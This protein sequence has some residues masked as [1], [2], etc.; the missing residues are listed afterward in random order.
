MIKINIPSVRVV[1]ILLVMVT[2]CTPTSDT[3][4]PPNLPTITPTDT[5]LVPTD[6]LT[7]VPTEPP[8]DEPIPTDA[9]LPSELATE[10]SVFYALPD[11]VFAYLLTPRRDSPGIT[12]EELVANPGALENQVLGR[13]RVVESPTGEFQPGDYTITLEPNLEVLSFNGP[14]DIVRVPVVIRSLPV[15]LPELRPVA[16][17][18]SLQMCLAWDTLQICGLVSTPLPSNLQEQLLGAIQE[19][20]ADP[21]QFDL[22]RGIPDVEGDNILEPCLNDIGQEEPSYRQCRSSVLAVPALEPLKALPADPD[23]IGTSVLVVLENLILENDVFADP[24]FTRPI[25][26]LPPGNYVM[27]NIVFPEDP[28]VPGFENWRA[29]LSRVG[30]SPGVGQDPQYYL[31]AIIGAPLTGDAVVGEPLEEPEAVIS[32]LW[33]RGWDGRWSCYFQWRQCPW[34]S[35]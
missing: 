26:E 1:I 33:V 3:P 20:G 10:Y 23:A 7:E 31:R 15:S 25:G 6:T 11:Q 16:M 30:L 21:E 32:N 34:V 27:Y 18:S 9:A 4:S 28:L 17:I 35:R 13:L 22:D 8:T 19:L 14:T 29:T 2:A 12:A 24:D 5:P